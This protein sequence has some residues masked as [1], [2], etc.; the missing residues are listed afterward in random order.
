MLNAIK[1][2]FSENIDAICNGFAL[3]NGE[4]FLPYND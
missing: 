4:D 3:I 1:K 2:Y